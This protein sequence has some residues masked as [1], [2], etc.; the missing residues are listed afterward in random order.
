M[1]LRTAE[2]GGASSQGLVKEPV[3]EAADGGENMPIDTEGTMLS[4]YYRASV[5]AGES[6]YSEITINGED[7]VG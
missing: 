1:C 3:A 6:T 2:D 5:T 7:Y 4:D